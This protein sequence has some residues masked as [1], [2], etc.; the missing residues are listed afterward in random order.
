MENKEKEEEFLKFRKFL[1]FLLH[2]PTYFE[3][4]IQNFDHH[5]EEIKVELKQYFDNF[6]REE[7]EAKAKPLPMMKT[8][9][10]FDETKPFNKQ[11][12]ERRLL[13]AAFGGKRTRN[14]KNYLKKTRKNRQKQRKYTLKRK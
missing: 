11:F 13:T 3:I 4:G 5:P 1:Y 7:I 12:S 10:T 8:G 9:R 14:R 6:I 2:L